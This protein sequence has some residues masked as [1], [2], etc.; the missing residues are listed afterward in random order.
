MPKTAGAITPKASKTLPK[1]TKKNSSLI[2]AC[3][4][5][6]RGQG[7]ALRRGCALSS[8]ATV[9][10]QSNQG[11]VLRP[12]LCGLGN[13]GLHNRVMGLHNRVFG[14]HN[15][16]LSRCRD[17]F[18]RVRIGFNDRVMG[19]HNGVVAGVSLFG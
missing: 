3:S 16:V 9:R 4:F 18:H 6:R 10:S 15:R 12:Q 2:G 8:P 14:F 13:I 1:T 19:L 7:S 11:A 17:G 5:G